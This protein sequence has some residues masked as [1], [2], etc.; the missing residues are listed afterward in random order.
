MLLLLLL[1][2]DGYEGV[3]RRGHRLLHGRVA[4]GVG[5]QQVAGGGVH[6]AAHAGRGVVDV[7][8][9]DVQRTGTLLRGEGVEASS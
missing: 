5:L 3:V 7:D 8:C 9:V 6:Q 4:E 1:L 2:L